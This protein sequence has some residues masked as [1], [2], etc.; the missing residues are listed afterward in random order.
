MAVTITE[1][2]IHALNIVK[3]EET[4]APIAVVFE[5]LLEQLGP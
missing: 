4:A 3:E 1:Q 5:T 2:T